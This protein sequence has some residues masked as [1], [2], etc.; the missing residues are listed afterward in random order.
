M[1]AAPCNPRPPRAPTP[2]GAATT[3]GQTPAAAD[4]LP[5]S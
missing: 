5:S 4:P 1:L 3:V 2:M